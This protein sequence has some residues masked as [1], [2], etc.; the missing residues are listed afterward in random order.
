MDALS[1]GKTIDNDCIDGPSYA[2]YENAGFK[3]VAC[4]STWLT[5]IYFLS[6]LTIVT[7]IF[8]NLFIAIIING[9]LDTLEDENNSVSGLK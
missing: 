7:L 6:Y 8:L 4:G 2:D 1:K 9:Y 5:N 3:P